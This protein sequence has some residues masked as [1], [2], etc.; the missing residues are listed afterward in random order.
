[1]ERGQ[2]II[3]DP[4]FWISLVSAAGTCIASWIMY[5]TLRLAERQEARRLPR[6][7]PYL[8]EGY[9]RTFQGERMRVYAF[10]I[11]VGNPSEIDNALARAELQ[12]GYLTENDVYMTVKVAE[13][14]FLAPLL[15]LDSRAVLRL[16][17]GVGAN[18]T[19][20]GW[21]FFRVNEDVL[22]EVRIDDYS[23]LLTDTND[24]KATLDLGIVREL[25]DE[26]EGTKDQG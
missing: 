18:Q 9:R 13:D 19:V 16:P 10:S 8:A 20:A 1:M 17:A 25:I 22:R 21:L 7:R 11:S 6:L 5:R 26:D 23:L 3:S 14:H 2:S 15:G 24:A 12:I 4:A